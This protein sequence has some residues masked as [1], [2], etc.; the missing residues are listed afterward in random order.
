MT[1]EDLLHLSPL[2]Q[3]DADGALSYT[4]A[5]IAQLLR[6]LDH[7]LPDHTALHLLDVSHDLTH[8]HRSLPCAVIQLCDADGGRRHALIQRE[9]D[10]R[11]A[12]HP[13]DCPARKL[14]GPLGSGCAR[15]QG[16]IFGADARTPRIDTVLQKLYRQGGVALSPYPLGG[17]RAPFPTLL[18]LNE[19]KLAAPV[20]IMGTHWLMGARMVFL[21]RG[22]VMLATDPVLVDHSGRSAALSLRGTFRMHRA[23]RAA[24]QV[25]RRVERAA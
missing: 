22:T 15:A 18:T 19:Q 5:P 21:D 4:P 12:L 10:G 3:R 16:W 2:D 1:T 20:Q 25:A 9:P 14:R 13:I 7:Q 17:L 23:Q 8:D 24:W 11:A 6:E